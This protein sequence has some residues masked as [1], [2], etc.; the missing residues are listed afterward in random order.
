MILLLTVGKVSFIRK[1]RRSGRITI[2]AMK[3]GVGKRWHGRYCARH[4]VHADGAVEDL[5]QWAPDQNCAMSYSGRLIKCFPCL[6]GYLFR[7]WRISPFSINLLRALS[8]SL[9]LI[10]CDRFFSISLLIC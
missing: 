9:T 3:V 10:A 7:S 1:V 6:G 4:F 5:S 2:L 8:S